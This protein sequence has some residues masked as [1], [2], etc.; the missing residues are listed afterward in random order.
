MVVSR[1][2]SSSARRADAI[3]MAVRDHVQSS[4]LIL[5]RISNYPPYVHKEALPTTPHFLAVS[6]I[7]IQA[8]AFVSCLLTVVPAGMSA[9]FEAKVIGVLD[10]D[11]IEDS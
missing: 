5:N 9:D 6:R 4:L 2:S 1:L 11:T 7:L 3:G 10:G 8:V